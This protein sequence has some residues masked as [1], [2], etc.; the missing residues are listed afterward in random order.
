LRDLNGRVSGGPTAIGSL[1]LH[2]APVNFW[3]GLIFELYRSQHVILK[4][5]S[6]RRISRANVTGSS[7]HSE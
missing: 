7:L 2:R 6:D 4:E 5:C 3:P 1:I